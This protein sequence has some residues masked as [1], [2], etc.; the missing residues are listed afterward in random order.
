MSCFVI[1]IGGTGAKCVEALIHLCAAGLMP[2]ILGA[3]GE[4]LAKEDLY[5]AFVDPDTSNGSLERASTTLKQYANCKQLQLGDVN[6]FKTPIHFVTDHDVWTPFGDDDKPQLDNFFRYGSLRLANKPIAHLFDVLYSRDEKETTLEKGFRGHP[7]IGAA[8][9]ASTLKFDEGE[10]WKTFRKRINQVKAGDEVKIILVG[11]VF[12]G[13]GAAGLPTIARLIRNELKDLNQQQEDGQAERK[14]RIGGILVL[15]YFK[16]D[17]VEESGIKAD[18]EDFLLSTQAAL[19]YYHQQAGEKMSLGIFDTVYTIGEAQL[20]P[21]KKPSLGST[22]QRN[23]QHFIELYSALACLDFFGNDRANKSYHM[24]AREKA[25]ELNWSDLPYAIQ[26]DVRKNRDTNELKK[27]IRG[28][29]RFTFAYLSSYYPALADIS[30]RRRGYRAPWY[31]NLIKRPGVKLKD[32]MD[33]EIKQVREYCESYLTWLAN[34]VA[35]TKNVKVELV[36]YDAFAVRKTTEDNKV[37]VVLRHG[38]QLEKFDELILGAK[39]VSSNG[40]NNLWARMCVASVDDTNASGIGK[41]FHAL[42]EE[43]EKE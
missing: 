41:F 30:H 4:V 17:P 3:Q 10:P 1:G 7:S 27:K 31:I 6:L 25:N 43:C 19:R 28:L 42:Y 18:S 36:N 35:V 13:T 29:T 20:S 26:V 40:L 38:F 37:E 21:V 23:E 9:L 16:F 39:D 2:D 15:P 32:V 12:G 34:T 24:I 5:V 11:S 33:K 22:E 8:V 14:A